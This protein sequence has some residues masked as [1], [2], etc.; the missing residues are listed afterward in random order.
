MKVVELLNMCAEM[1]KRLHEN[2]IVMEDY[3][4]LPLLVDYQ[5]MKE[6]GEKTTY[7]V[8]VLSEKYK[9]CER[10]VYKLI[11]IFMKDC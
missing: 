6:E 1:M 2:G 4:F 10:R 11:S 3:Q 8:A 7:A 5:R 9:I